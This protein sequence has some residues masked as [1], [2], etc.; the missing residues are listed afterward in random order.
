M[1]SAL[2][3]LHNERIREQ[4]SARERGIFGGS[5]VRAIVPHARRARAGAKTIRAL[6]IAFFFPRAWRNASL[7]CRPAPQAH[8]SALIEVAQ[9][10]QL[11]GVSRQCI[12]ALLRAAPLSSSSGP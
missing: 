1:M 9:V 11:Y 5:P 2:I 4:D 7:Q 6:T 10:A 12:Y 8:F 3:T